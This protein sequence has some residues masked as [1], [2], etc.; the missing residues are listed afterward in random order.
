MGTDISHIL[1]D[2]VWLYAAADGGSVGACGPRTAGKVPPQAPGPAEAD[3]TITEPCHE[4]GHLFGSESPLSDLRRDERW[5]SYEG[6]LFTWRLRVVEVSSR[7]FGGYA[8]QYKC[9]RSRSLIQD[10]QVSYPA[11]RKGFVLPLDLGKAVAEA[12]QAVQPT[13]SGEIS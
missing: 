8:V 1:L 12:E 13:L 10:V 9:A 3:R 2:S 11:G 4:L 7:L 6:R 5:K